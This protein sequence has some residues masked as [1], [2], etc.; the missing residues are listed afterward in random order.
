MY[1]RVALLLGHVLVNHVLLLALE[2]IVVVT[3][4]LKIVL[5]RVT[6][7]A[8]VEIGRRLLLE[9]RV[10]F[11][12]LRTRAIVVLNGAMELLLGRGLGLLGLLS[13]R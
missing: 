10:L 11:L 4:P 8:A 12:C 7:H 9:R 5:M 3:L 6:P 2:V 1:C 13:F